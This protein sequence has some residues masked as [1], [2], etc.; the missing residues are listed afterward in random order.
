MPA[1]YV[2]RAAEKFHPGLEAWVTEAWLAVVTDLTG[3]DWRLVSIA[4]NET[5]GFK[6]L[7]VYSQ[8]AVT[9]GPALIL[10]KVKQAA[11][12]A[13]R[14]KLSH[15][16]L[17]E[18]MEA[19]SCSTDIYEAIHRTIKSHDEGDP[20][21]PRRLAAAIQLIRKLQNHNYWG[22][23]A[24]NKAFCWADDLPRGRGVTLATAPIVRE[25]AA[26]LADRGIFKKKVSNGGK[27]YALN[28]AHIQTLD[29]I[30]THEWHRLDLGLQK[31]LLGDRDQV[32]ARETDEATQGWERDRGEWSK[33]R[34][35]SESKD[36]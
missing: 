28:R 17:V 34:Q 25:V 14:T 31:Y 19:P 23:E 3:Q 26:E 27:K 16:C 18:C 4:T 33:V 35:D 12:A 36:D 7:D 1:L 6:P 5:N 2:I 21:I 9:K 29:Y 22:G 32:S 20:R 10:G 24:K 30:V 11:I 15:V 8:I 13:L